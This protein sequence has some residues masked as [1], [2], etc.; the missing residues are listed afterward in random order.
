[1]IKLKDILSV[2]DSI[3]YVSNAR[4]DS[5]VSIDTRF[6]LSD[7]FSKDFLNREVKILNASDNRIKIWLVEEE[8]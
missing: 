8:K 5:M 2:V 1:M 7:F 4:G 3:V 6:A